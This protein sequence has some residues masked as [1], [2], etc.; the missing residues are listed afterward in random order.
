MKFS[1]AFKVGLL[2][3]ISILLLLG[4][5]VKVKGKAFSGAKRLEVQFNDVN[6][7]RPGAAVQMMGMKVGQ[8]EDVK[9]VFAD[10][11]N[12]VNVKFVITDSNVTIPKASAFS[13]QQSGLI[14]EL[15]L[16]ITPPRTRTTYIPMVK[17]DILYADDV[18]KMNL[19]KTIY[20][21]GKIKNVE[22][23]SR[24]LVPYSL[25]EIVGTNLA[26]KID[27][28]I[29]LPG[30][31]LP[32]FMKAKYYQTPDGENS[33]LISTLDDIVLPYPEQKSDYTVIEPMRIS[34]FLEWQLRAAEGLTET[35][36]KINELL[37]EDVIG[38]LQSSVGNIT[39]L[40]AD[41]S[42]L[43]NRVNNFMEKDLEDFIK[44]VDKSAKDFHTLS[45]SL[46]RILEDDDV[47]E[48]LIKTANSFNDMSKNIDI[49][50]GD[51]ETSKQLA[52]DFR[53]IVSNVNEISK[54]VES[55]TKDQTLKGSLNSSIKNLNSAMLDISTALAPLN[56][57]NC[58]NKT[59]IQAIIDDTAVTTANLKKFSEKLNKR[60]LLFRLMF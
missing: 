41:A 51:D 31:I 24:D 52:S 45:V 25:R 22:V 8:V 60:F 47:R 11:K 38:E 7:L 40:T 20:D 34:D 46:N 23:V 36:K 28:S 48:T 26:Y 10:D 27:Y 9:P 18:V 56:S 12:Y 53:S 58:D 55:M 42:A 4:V 44:I 43:L 50:F 29:N 33:L 14:G 19:D 30:L 17:K 57:V 13:I 6:G 49:L 32:E 37:S 59:E 39:T 15:F 35:N 16:E 54:F 2:T 1:S 21:V 5:V 3:F